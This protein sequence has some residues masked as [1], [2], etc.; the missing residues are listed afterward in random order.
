M[1]KYLA[2]LFAVLAVSVTAQAGPI[3][4]VVRCVVENRPGIIFPKQTRSPY[5]PATCEQPAAFPVLAQAVE[6]VKALPAY[7]RNLTL[8]PGSFGGCGPFGCPK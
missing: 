3:R 8:L 7:I 2:T 4:N 5:A 6:P 1:K